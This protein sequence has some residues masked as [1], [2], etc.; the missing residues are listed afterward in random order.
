MPSYLY[1][2]MHT[3]NEQAFKLMD[4][5]LIALNACDKFAEEV[6]L[7]S[8]DPMSLLGE[9][10]LPG[11]TTL[12]SLLSTKDYHLL[13]SILTINVGMGI[14]MFDKIKPFFLYVM[15][16]QGVDSKNGGDFLD[17]ALFNIAKK[18]H[19]GI[20]GL[21]KI[22]DQL[23]LVNT[24]PLKK[25]ADMLAEAAHNFGKTASENDETA[26]LMKYYAERDLDK[27]YEMSKKDTMD[28]ENFSE[29]FVTKRNYVMAAGIRNIMKTNTV[30]V[31]VGALHLAGLEGIIN[32][33]RKNG[34]TVRPVL[35]KKFLEPKEVK[36]SVK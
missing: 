2:T 29:D 10:T 25:Q 34:Y 5:V 3:N 36:V 8:L 27:M 16:E 13:D 20:Y 15:A 21:E 26:L 18:G 22:Q 24:I 23:K 9:I 14:A 31:A 32:I 30:F 1:G 4:S 12:S 35:S 19:K 7:D 33:L 11:D 6:N 17:L 28:F